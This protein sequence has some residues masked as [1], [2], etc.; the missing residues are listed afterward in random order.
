MAVGDIRDD[1]RQRAPGLGGTL[2]DEPGVIGML[3]PAI[4]FP[5]YVYDAAADLA[6][7]MPRLLAS[8]PVPRVHIT[9]AHPGRDQLEGAGWDLDQCVTQMVLPLAQRFGPAPDVPGVELERVVV[10]DGIE[11]FHAA[12]SAGFGD[13]LD[14]PEAEVPR[15]VILSQ[16]IRLFVARDE[17]GAI[18]GTAGARRRS[19]G[20]T[21]FAISV[22]PK[23]RGRGIGS[24][25]T[26]RATEE[27]FDAGASSVQLQATVAGHSV[28]EHAGFGMAGRWVFYRPRVTAAR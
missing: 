16:G 2:L 1:L 11:E 21:L 9:E 6:A 14:H 3:S 7:V 17:N 23:A 12:M 22:L 15:D 28:Y 4:P 18:L 27:M 26:T 24:A 5:C 25:L 10:P 20:A 8:S 13:A 19:R